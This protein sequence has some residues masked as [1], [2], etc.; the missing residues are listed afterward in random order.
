MCEITECVSCVLNI[1][2][3]RRKFHSENEKH[4]NI[5]FRLNVP[6]YT[7]TVSLFLII[8]IDRGYNSPK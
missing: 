6:Y 7:S 5:K 8:A 3:F 1:W 4:Q 2:K